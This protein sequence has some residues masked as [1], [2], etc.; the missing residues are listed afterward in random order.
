VQHGSAKKHLSDLDTSN[1]MVF[2]LSIGG[3]GLRRKHV[4][5]TWNWGTISMFA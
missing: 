2:M 4:V 5:A 3:G 1:L